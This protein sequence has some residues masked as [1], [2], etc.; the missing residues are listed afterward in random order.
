MHHQPAKT[1]WPTCHYSCPPLTTIQIS[2]RGESYWGRKPNPIAFPVNILWRLPIIFRVK[3]K[4]LS[5]AQGFLWSA[6]RFS[7]SLFFFFF[8]ATFS[9]NLSP[10]ISKHLP[11]FDLAILS[12]CL[13]FKIKD[14]FLT[15]LVHFHSSFKFYLRY[16]LL[17]MSSSL[18]GLVAAPLW[19]P[20]A[21]YT[22]PIPVFLFY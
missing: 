3:S 11:L 19:C 2:P 5:V 20:S 12:I 10:G 21:S 9:L 22:H 16:N 15:T 4:I 6:S 7:F 17:R 14:A 1:N 8:W 18:L 13:F